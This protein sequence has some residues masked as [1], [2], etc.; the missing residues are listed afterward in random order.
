M[1]EIPNPMT[2]EAAIAASQSLL[3]QMEQNQL[4]ETELE[5]IVS[6][7]VNTANG[8]RGFF[9]TYL[10]DARPFADTP[11]PAVIQALQSSPDT[12]TEFV[13]KNLAMST[14]MEITHQR[15]GNSE[16]EQQSAQVRDRST[17]LIKL[18]NCDRLRTE[19]QELH[20]SIV[21]ASGN[22][23]GFLKKWGYDAE[24]QQAIATRLETVFPELGATS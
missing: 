19:A 8:V 12:V 23:A 24:Q 16:L 6:E 15:N 5:A 7:L 22:Y 9:V 1:I 11:T 3:N 20:Q 18:M 13:V 4:P 21:A 10:T 17:T 14:A 2:F